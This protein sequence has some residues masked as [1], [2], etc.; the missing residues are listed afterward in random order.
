MTR[1][2]NP[3]A[4]AHVARERTMVEVVDGAGRAIGM[5]SVADA[6]TIPGRRHR[7]YSVLVFDHH[8][9][10]LLQRRAAAKTRFAGHWSNTCCGHP[11]P[12]ENVSLAAARRLAEEMGMSD[13]QFD[14]AGHFA[15]RAVDKATGRVEDEYDH[16]LVGRVEAATPTPDPDEVSDWRWMEPSDLRADMLANPQQYTPWLDDV[17]R[18]SGLR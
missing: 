10:V 7:A 17:L 15:Y 18:I 8:G 2:P 4:A 3:I 14:E 13:I 6:H 5:C 9:R 12:G 16:V 1:H 11:S